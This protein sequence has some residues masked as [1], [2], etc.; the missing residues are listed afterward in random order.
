[1]NRRNEQGFSLLELLIAMMIIAVLGTLGFNQVRKRSAQARYLKAQDDLKIVSEGLDQYYLAHGKY[2][3]FGSY[4][5]MVDANSVLVK[6]NLIKANMGGTDPFGA[7]YEGK[8]NRGTYELKCQG[9][10]ND[11]EEHGPF[12]RTPSQGAQQT[13]GAAATPKADAGAPK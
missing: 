5:A 13:G 4:E 11:P 7:P 3:D 6:G 9:D 1:M 10:P 12:T 2:P 8:S